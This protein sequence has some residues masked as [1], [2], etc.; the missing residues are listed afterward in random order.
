MTNLLAEAQELFPYTQKMRRD[1]HRHPELGFQEKRTSRRIV[2]ELS[3][4]PGLDVKTGVGS[5][6]VVA[7][8]AC[9]KPGPVVLLRVD[10]D[11]LPIVEENDV[12]YASQNKGIMH[13]C[14]H[15]GHTAIG[16]TV[17]KIL[18]AER[19]NL[20]GTVKFVFQPAEEGDGGAERMIEDGVLENP[21]PDYALALHLWNEKPLGWYGI[22]AG[23]MMAAA[24]TISITV[25]GKGG[26]G[27]TPHA[28]IDPILAA[29]HIVTSLQSITSR[30]IAPVDA[31]VVS[32]TSIHGGSSH[33]IIPPKVELQG[34]TRS[35]DAETREHILKRVRQI[36]VGV[37]DAFR[38]QAKVDI[39]DVCPAVINDPE[40]TARAQKVT[41]QLFP[42]ATIATEYQTMGAEDMAWM[43]DK[44]P[45]CYML[46]GSANPSKGLDAKHHHPRFDFDEEALIYGTALASAVVVDLLK[47]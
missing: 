21:R 10:M 5:T 4:L 28:A 27:A 31:G 3:E 8:M 26:H 13:A 32:I 41:R 19:E 42:G 37:A 33:N 44:I 36:V 25:T 35:F 17:A 20:A 45:G 2:E 38:C 39:A 22:P 47:N 40:V 16:L 30:E 34:T 43:M 24:E 6:G 15:D 1:F 9:G 14:G 7:V 29:S 12:P 18:H 46:I 23:P 11:A